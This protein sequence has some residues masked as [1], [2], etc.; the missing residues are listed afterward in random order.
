MLSFS[1]SLDR[2]LFEKEFSISPATDLTFGWNGD[3]TG[4]TIGPR[5]S[6]L[7]L[8]LYRWK[9]TGKITDTGGI[10]LPRQYD[11]SFL[12]QLDTTPPRIL[13]VNPAAD[14]GDGTFTPMPER[15][16]CELRS[17]EHLALIFSEAIDH[18]SLRQ[19]L[20]ISPPIEG[21]LLEKGPAS[22]L[23]HISEPLPPGSEYGITV[24]KGLKDSSGNRT[25][26]DWIFR[27]SPDIPALKILNIDIEDQSGLYRRIGSDELG[28]GGYIDTPGLKYF[29]GGK[30]H[31]I[32][33]HSENFPETSHGAR[34]AF[35]ELISLGAVFP[36][37]T[38]P[39]SLFCSAWE[40]DSRLRLIY[41]GL[42]SHHPGKPVYYRFKISSG[43]TESATPEG[44][45][46][47]RKHR[48]QL[49]RGG[50]RVRR[51][52]ATAFALALLA[53]SCAGFNPNA[54]GGDRLEPERRDRRPGRKAPRSR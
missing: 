14:N 15:T 47:H 10:P 53:A 34:T 44:F 20:T 22:A 29:G 40:S 38:T 39:P 11:G 12:V 31:L 28:F 6:W 4:V 24:G 42:E 1:R 46:S 18:E 16:A 25:A 27:F 48:L 21:F 30:L 19:T 43:G 36:P 3:D 8:E 41:S 52:A 49:P 35:A 37:G 51:P 23:Y 50:S 7:N 9:L 26:D 33:A 13:S 54:A 17:G 2:N 45:L 5:S 32:I